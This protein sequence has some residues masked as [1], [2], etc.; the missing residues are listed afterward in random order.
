MPAPKVQV[1]DANDNIIGTAVTGDGNTGSQS[2]TA[3]LL[4]NGA[5]YDRARS[6]QDL[7]LINATAATSNTG[8]GDQTN[9]NGRGLK[10][11]LNTTAIGTGSITVTIQGKDTASG[12]YYTILAGAAV[13]TNTTNVYSVYPGLTVA[14]NT[15]ANDVLPHTWR[16][17]VT[18]N[19]ANPATYTVGASLIL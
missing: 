1:L 15:T 10:V 19:N 11:V 3:T 7:A 8:S 13:T 4:F 5:S 16:V 6:N 17:T 9:V 18:A 14:A 12:A 2:G